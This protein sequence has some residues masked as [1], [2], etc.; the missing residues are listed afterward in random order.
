MT[1]RTR[2]GTVVHINEAFR[3]QKTTGQQRYAA[4][5]ANRLAASAVFE[6]LEPPRYLRQSRLL[7]W[8]WTLGILPWHARK[9]V[10]LSLTSRTPLYHP[11]HVVVVHDIFV[12]TNPEWYSPR[13]VNTHAPLLR[14]T[15]RGARVVVAVSEPVAR[16]VRERNLTAASVVVAPNAAGDQFDRSLVDSDDEVLQRFGLVT[17]S[18]LLTV[19]SIEPRKNLDRLVAAYAGL[20]HDVRRRIP[21]VLVGGGSEVF[22]QVKLDDTPGV[23]PLGYVTDT[24]L[25]ALYRHSR[26]VVFPSLAEGFGLPIVE[27]R[28]AG[29]NLAVSDI[30]VFR[31]IAGDEVDYFDPRSE[32]AIRSALERLVDG[33]VAD[34]AGSQL[35]SGRF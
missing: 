23:R 22:R 11:R 3:G 17:D 35:H 2:R 33:Q 1:D 7:S 25:A 21:L 27:A 18:Y 16:Q 14:L 28:Q 4:S 31:W 5:I 9:G 26:G 6:S 30:E 13:Y 32:E 34:G 12:L 10:L 20:P 15:L 29:A 8:L 19:G 24:D